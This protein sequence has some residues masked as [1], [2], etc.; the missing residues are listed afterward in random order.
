MSKAGN[1]VPAPV[2]RVFDDLQAALPGTWVKEFPATTAKLGLRVGESRVVL[3]YNSYRKGWLDTSAQL[4]PRL[5]WFAFKP[6]PNKPDQF[7]AVELAP[8]RVEEI[9]RSRR[10]EI[11]A[12]L[13]AISGHG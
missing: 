11:V 4:G 3:T 9:Y 7:W 13:S 2:R 10:E 5:R 12:A 1:G 6:M 8:E